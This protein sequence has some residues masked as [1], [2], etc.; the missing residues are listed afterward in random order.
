MISTSSRAALA[1]L[2]TVAVGAAA[3]S[4]FGTDPG[5]DPVSRD[6][7]P[8]TDGGDGDAFDPVK[9]TPQQ[10][11]GSNTGRD[12]GGKAD[13]AEW[14]PKDLP[15]LAVWLDSTV[16]AMFD[17]NTKLTSWADQSGNGN[18]ATI[19]PP[20]IGPARAANS[21]NGHDTLAFTGS[22]AV[23]A[24]VTIADATSL[25]FGTNDFAIFVVARYTNVPNVLF[26]STSTANLW[27]KYLPE[28]KPPGNPFVGV[29]LIA[30]TLSDSKLRIQQNNFSDPWTESATASLNDNVFRRLGGTRRGVTMEVWIDGA[31]DGSVALASSLDVSQPGQSASIGG[32]PVQNISWL[33]GNIA[34]VVAVKGTLSDPQ[35][36]QLDGYFKAKHGL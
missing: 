4:S 16:G 24:C 22:G 29:R 19:K 31:S 18:N 25:Q 17:V 21:L 32:D 36:K 9:G 7:S 28:Q 27:E 8:G 26:S 14:S 6:A 10:D 33:Q 30:N 35:I 11:S 3:C 1:L 23:G 20:C 13:A 12:A 5:H 34:E 2:L 15:G